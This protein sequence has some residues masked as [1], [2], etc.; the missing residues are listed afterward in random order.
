MKQKGRPGGREAMATRL[1]AHVTALTVHDPP[2]RAVTCTW[3]WCQGH[4]RLPGG[5]ERGEG[6]AVWSTEAR[7]RPGDAV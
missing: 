1:C 7:S 6:T 4:S 3:R 2:A 5:G